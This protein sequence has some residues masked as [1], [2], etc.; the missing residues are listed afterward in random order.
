[1]TWVKSD[2]VL[3]EKSMFAVSVGKADEMRETDDI[4]LLN[5][6]ECK[7]RNITHDKDSKPVP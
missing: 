2:I 6:L 7:G 5:V 4:G 3:G 1:M